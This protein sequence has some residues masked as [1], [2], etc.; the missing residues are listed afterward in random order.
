[1]VLFARVRDKE[2]D[3]LKKDEEETRRVRFLKHKTAVKPLLLQQ[4][5]YGICYGK[6]GLLFVCSP[7][8][9][10]IFG[11]GVLPVLNNIFAARHF[12][13]GARI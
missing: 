1:M 7:H 9:A 10:R 8:L 4:A 2:E 6:S 11:H 13:S 12:L 5:L 3:I